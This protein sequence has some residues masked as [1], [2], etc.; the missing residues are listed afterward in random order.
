MLTDM[1][2]L[3]HPDF[4]REYNLFTDASRIATGVCFTPTLYD[5]VRIKEV[6]KPIYFL[7]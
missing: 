5:E 4:I 2:T 6:E 1:V 7:S 3:E